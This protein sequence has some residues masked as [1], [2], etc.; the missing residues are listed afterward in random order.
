MTRIIGWGMLIGVLAW[1][2]IAKQTGFEPS[3]VEVIKA[4]MFVIAG[5][6]LAK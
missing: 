4:I 1:F 6:I 2:I 5:A 3:L